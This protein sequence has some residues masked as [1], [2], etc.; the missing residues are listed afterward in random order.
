MA[1][2]V[3]EPDSTSNDEWHW[4][5]NSALSKW[6]RYDTWKGQFGLP[7]ICNIDL[8]NSGRSDEWT[9][10]VLSYPESA[11]LLYE[12]FAGVALLSEDPI[13]QLT[14]IKIPT[15][16]DLAH[17]I[18]R[19]TT[20][21]KASSRDDLKIDSD[22]VRFR[23]TERHHAC[24]E[25]DEAHDMFMS[26]PS[27]GETDTFSPAYFL[28]WAAS[29][30]IE[31]PWLDW[32]KSHGLVNMTQSEPPVAKSEKKASSSKTGQVNEL[33]EAAVQMAIR[34]VNDGMTKKYITVTKICVWLIESGKFSTRKPFTTR[35]RE[36]EGIRSLLKGEHNPLSD[37]RYLAAKPI[38]SPKF[39]P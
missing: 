7:L 37:K 23:M 18:R 19:L 17:N 39:N 36:P 5:E 38:R 35:W 1:E 29:K 28:S 2:K 6:L 11:H 9:R 26:N 27:H 14:P 22:D 4:Y 33:R 20:L 34:R 15:R 3:V 21:K 25:L 31:I 30:R 8:Q 32:A 16:P 10:L 24:M 12:D 13:Y